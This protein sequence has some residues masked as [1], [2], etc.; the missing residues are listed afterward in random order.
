ML[1]VIGAGLGR[2]GTN[3]LK[4]ALEKLGFDKCY[5]MFELMQA[6]HHQR[7]FEAAHA[8][9][10]V[11]WDALF[12]GFQAAVDYPAAAFY[13]ELMAHYPA[14]KVILTVRDP[15]RWYDSVRETIYASSRRG[16][17]WHTVATLGSFHPAIRHTRRRRRFLDRLIWD[18]QFEGRFEDR[19]H[20]IA[21]FNRWNDE[22][23]QT[24]PAE[25]LLVYQ[26]Q[27]GW[28]PLCDFLD[29]P[30]P[31]EPFPRSNTRETFKQHV[32]EGNPLARWFGL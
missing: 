11:D 1:K 12:T 19:A 30:A 22:V 17:L 3:S 26:V 14:A 18:G 25:R 5:H 20:T 32:R 23:Q 7:Y 15:E 21:A 10:P 31:D 27:E 28:Q 9:Q 4:I 16:K 8:G 29:V 6:P 13:R 2:T 24:V